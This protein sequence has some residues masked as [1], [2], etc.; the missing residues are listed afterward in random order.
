MTEYD[1][2]N[3]GAIFKND[4]KETDSH[5]DYKGSLNVNGQEF[6]VS[7]WINQSKAGTKYMS[8]KVTAKEGQAGN[9]LQNST[10]KVTQVS[11]EPDF[12]EDIPF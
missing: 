5:P 1:N 8:L 9:N 11:N 10:P 7:S 12:D 2:T 4:K 6:W 3:S